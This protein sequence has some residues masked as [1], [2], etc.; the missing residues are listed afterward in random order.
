MTEHRL[1]LRHIGE[2]DYT[3]MRDGRAI[4]RIR[5]AD[6][7]TESVTWEWAINP[8]LPIPSWARGTA[9]TLQDAKTA[10]QEAWR[11]FYATLTPAD[12]ERWHRDQDRARERS[13]RFGWT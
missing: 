1:S 4:G 5:L 3:V 8:P 9:A 12:I 6:E 7:R 11:R 13:E 2:N 10:F